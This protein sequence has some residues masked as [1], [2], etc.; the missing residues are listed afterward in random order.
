[1]SPLEPN[2]ERRRWR[3]PRE[4]GEVLA[5]PPL[6]EMPAV[7][8]RNRELIAT[9]DTQVLG[10]PLADLRRVAREEVLTAAE[11]FTHPSE[12]RA[13]E[14]SDRSLALQRPLIVGGHQ[15]EL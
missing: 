3:A 7:I 1:M 9:W 2:W 15:P 14:R 13:N 11:R 6:A 8:A 4:D 5:I 12:S 10:R